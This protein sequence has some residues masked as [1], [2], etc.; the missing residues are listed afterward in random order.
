MRIFAL[1]LGVF[2]MPAALTLRSQDFHSPVI[3]SPYSVMIGDVQVGTKSAPQPVTVVNTG[4][5]VVHI[6]GVAVMGNFSQTND[7]PMPPMG[8]GHNETCAIQ[9]FFEPK[10]VGAASGTLTITDDVPGGSLTAM[11]SGNGALG[12]PQITISPRSV[13]T[14]LARWCM[15]SATCSAW[16]TAVRTTE[17]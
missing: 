2:L 10:E 12:K 11:L 5:N 3:L 4:T 8:L 6:L 17:R 1:L 14:V 16:V 7:C 9:V 13:A 15:N